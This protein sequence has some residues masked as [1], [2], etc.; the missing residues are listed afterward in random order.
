MANTVKMKQTNKHTHK[1][2]T[3]DCHSNE[4]TRYKPGK[5][6]EK[7]S[8]GKREKINIITLVMNNDQNTNVL[9]IDFILHKTPKNN[10]FITDIYGQ[11]R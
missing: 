6:R 7:R 11:T 3:V 1:R 9:F 10:V 2:E 5:T 4:V 8:T